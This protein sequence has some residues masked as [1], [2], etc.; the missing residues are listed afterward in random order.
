M[1]QRFDSII[2]IDTGC[3]G[4]KK[5]MYFFY[6]INMWTLLFLIVVIEVFVVYLLLTRGVMM[7]PKAPECPEPKLPKIEDVKEPDV[8]IGERTTTLRPPGYPTTIPRPP[9]EP[10]TIPRPRVKIRDIIVDGVNRADAE[11]GEDAVFEEPS[12]TGPSTVLEAEIKK[13]V[14]GQVLFNAPEEMKVGIKERVEV[15]IAKNFPG[16]LTK[17]LKGKGIPETVEIKVNTLMSVRLRGENFYIKTL[18]P[19]GQLVVDAEFTEWDYDVTPLKSGAQELSLTVTVRIKVPDYDEQERANPV[20]DKLIQVKPN[21]WF[22]LVSFIK[23][24]W[25]WLVGGI[26]GS[27]IIGWIVKRWVT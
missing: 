24:N 6:L 26:T 14:P 27:G 25:K 22:S 20:Y 7:A 2:K 19:E 16:D 23:N 9:G 15:R 5:D 17:G 11:R 13:L 18:S 8:P 10:T 1:S 4:K 21:P 3:K 12:W